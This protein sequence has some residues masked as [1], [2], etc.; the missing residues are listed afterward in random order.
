M[1]ITT[2]EEM[3]DVLVRECIDL[4]NHHAV[5]AALFEGG[6][7]TSIINQFMAEAIDE[8]RFARLFAV[9]GKYDLPEAA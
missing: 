7:K 6:F 1:M 9:G 4:D 3:A 5:R 8:A 2:A